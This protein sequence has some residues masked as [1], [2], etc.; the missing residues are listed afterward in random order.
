MSIEKDENSENQIKRIV[1]PPNT[2]FL[3]GKDGEPEIT[4]YYSLTNR[5]RWL[6]RL[7]LLDGDE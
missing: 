5:E 2:Y 7:P 4:D 3:I 1:L 6:L